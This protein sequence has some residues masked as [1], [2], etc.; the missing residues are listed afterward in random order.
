[1]QKPW[2]LPLD[3][4]MMFTNADSM[5]HEWETSTNPDSNESPE[6]KTTDQNNKV[7]WFHCQE[8]FKRHMDRQENS[9]GDKKEVCSLSRCTIVMGF[10]E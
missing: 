3:Q 9:N 6:T 5:K 8:K 1:M 4:E 2:Q 10:K 7:K